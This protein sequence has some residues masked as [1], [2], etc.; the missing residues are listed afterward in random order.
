MTTPSAMSLFYQLNSRVESLL[1]LG[2]DRT[3]SNSRD[4]E[5]IFRACVVLLVSALDTYMHEKSFNIFDARVQQGASPDIDRYLG[6]VAAPLTYPSS[7]SLIRYRLSFK[8]LVA[9]DAIDDCI[10]A[11]GV[12]ASEVWWKI[13]IDRG[14]RESRLRNSLSISYDRRNS[15]SHEGDW[16]PVQL[17]FRHI[18]DTHV[19]DCQACVLEVAEGI[20][21]HWI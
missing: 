21:R 5:A 18:S 20:E 12:D 16:D 8:T 1:A 3:S 19:V 4:A 10:T 9:P 13:G 6:T 15:I 17:T 14:S 11:S 7:T 2:R